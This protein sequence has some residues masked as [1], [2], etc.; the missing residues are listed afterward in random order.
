MALPR[1]FYY[2]IP[3]VVLLSLSAGWVEAYWPEKD[4]ECCSV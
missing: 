3:L 1:V 2:L 4:E